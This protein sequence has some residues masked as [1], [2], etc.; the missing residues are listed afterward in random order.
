LLDAGH[1][2]AVNPQ[3]V[4]ELVGDN[5][6]INSPKLLNRIEFLQTISPALAPFFSSI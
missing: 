2:Y 1:E 4:S 3:V 6:H 5:P